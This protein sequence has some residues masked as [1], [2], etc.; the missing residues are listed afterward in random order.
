[1][2]KREVAIGTGIPWTS[3]LAVLVIVRE[4]MR[5]HPCCATVSSRRR[6]FV[7]RAR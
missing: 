6:K 4:Y 7:R 2:L 5:L 3:L 1:V